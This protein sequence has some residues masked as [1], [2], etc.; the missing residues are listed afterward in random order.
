MNRQ[1][2]YD[3]KTVSDKTDRK[4]YKFRKPDGK[5]TDRV[6]VTRSVTHDCQIA[7]VVSEDGKVQQEEVCLK[8][9]IRAELLRFATE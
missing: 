2:Y 3:C 1:K 8:E 5:E 6:K 4:V 9:L 7:N